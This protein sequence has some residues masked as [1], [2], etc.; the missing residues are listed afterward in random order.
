M[1]QIIVFSVKI[2]IVLQ[3]L[4]FPL[5]G[6]HI[7]IA[8]IICQNGLFFLPYHSAPVSTSNSSQEVKN[9]LWSIEDLHS[10]VVHACDIPLITVD[11][12]RLRSLCDILLLCRHG[13]HVHHV[14]SNLGAGRSGHRSWYPIGLVMALN[15]LDMDNIPLLQVGIHFHPLP[16]QDNIGQRFRS[17]K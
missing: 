1:S 13:V 3:E 16:K 14:Q 8:Q 12:V 6:N 4:S 11:L 15:N 2:K 17:G 10:E 9:Y 7:A 5:I